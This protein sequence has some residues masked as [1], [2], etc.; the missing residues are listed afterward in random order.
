MSV[1][2][3][4]LTGG[5]RNPQQWTEEEDLYFEMEFPVMDRSRAGTIDSFSS[6]D[7]YGSRSTLDSR[8]SPSRESRESSSGA[9]ERP[10]TLREVV[11]NKQKIIK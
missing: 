7:S 3:P 1:S 2:G 5:P 11:N 4:P 6:P 10:N 9:R 8:E